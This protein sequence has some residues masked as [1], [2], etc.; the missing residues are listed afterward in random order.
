MHI[1][2]S[3]LTVTG[4]FGTSGFMAGKPHPDSMGKAEI[5]AFLSRL[6][7]QGK[8]SATTQRQGTERNLEKDIFA[9]SSRLDRLLKADSL[10]IRYHVT[11]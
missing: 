9:V 1:A 5:D 2:P 6:A 3:K 11:S 4:S 7:T 10:R 8:V